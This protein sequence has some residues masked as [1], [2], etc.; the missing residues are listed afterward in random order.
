MF[1]SLLQNLEQKKLILQ[2]FCAYV[3]IGSGEESVLNN[4]LDTNV[5]LFKH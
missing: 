1:F 2:V 3:L 5:K 4:R